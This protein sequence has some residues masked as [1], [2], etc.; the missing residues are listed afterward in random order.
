MKMIEYQSKIS[1]SKNRILMKEPYEIE[2]YLTSDLIKKAV[3]GAGA[4]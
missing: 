2:L 3:G 1:K 4:G